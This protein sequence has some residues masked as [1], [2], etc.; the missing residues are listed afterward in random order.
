L[1]RHVQ[2]YHTPI[3]NADVPEPRASSDPPEDGE[4]HT[5]EMAEDSLPDVIDDLDFPTEIDPQRR[6]APR[7][8]ERD[9]GFAI[10]TTDWQ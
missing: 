10:S 4:S 5:Q 2:E 7:N 3:D 8:F 1:K 6:P 9:D